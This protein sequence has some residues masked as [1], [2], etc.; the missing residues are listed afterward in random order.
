MVGLQARQAPIISKTKELIA[1]GRIGKVLNSTWN[2]YSLQGG[3]SIGEGMA[4]FTEKRVGGNFWTI[5]VAH[6][7]DYVQC[8][9]SATDTITNSLYV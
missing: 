6:A 5:H 8:G 3:K 9:K 1:S 4:Y 2:G 7:L